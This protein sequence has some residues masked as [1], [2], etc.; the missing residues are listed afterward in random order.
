MSNPSH[1]SAHLG[2][3]KYYYDFLL[4]FQSEMESKGWENVLNEYIFAGDERADDMLGRMFAGFL[5]P[6]IHLG[7]GLEFNQP[8]IIAEALAQA[9]IH[10]TWTKDFLLN[11]EKIS[12]SRPAPASKSLPEVLDA[13]FADQKLSKAAQ[14][15]DGNKIRDGILVRA[16]E[17]ITSH[18]LSWVPTA[19]DLELNTLEM[20]NAGIYFTAC[21]QHP[22]KQV[23]FDFYFM[24]CV[25]CS[26][27]FPTFNAQTWLSTENKVRLLKFKVWLDLAMYASRRS[28][29][30]LLDEVTAYVPIK[31]EAGDAEWPG[32]FR[33]LSEIESEDG[34]AVK[35]G[36]AVRN[37]QL[38]SEDW[39]RNGGNEEKMRIKGPMW[40][41]IGN[42][43]VDSVEDTGE[44]WV[45]S[46]GFEEAW[47]EFKDRPK[48]AQ[49]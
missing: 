4:F 29:K 23:K 15:G 12:N 6:L 26:I 9:A 18:A 13:I 38:M 24:H 10:D 49:L 33:R 21:A 39:V 22:P 40:E 45:R 48:R 41:K 28:P 32:I 16:P 1:F 7:F 42:M 34:H 2:K 35:L 36:R 37:A 19:E 20:V 5:H 44:H 3:E 31:P 14:W 47:T 11:T 27:F 8:A 17:E 43:V 46:A 25:N 30:L